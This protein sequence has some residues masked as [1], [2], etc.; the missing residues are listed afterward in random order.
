MWQAIRK[1]RRSSIKGCAVC[2]SACSENSRRKSATNCRSV[3]FSLFNCR[4]TKNRVANPFRLQAE[5]SAARRFQQPLE[6]LSHECLLAP[7]VAADETVLGKLW[8]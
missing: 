7:L 3:S 5:L 6:E 4:E 2:G 8:R 1:V